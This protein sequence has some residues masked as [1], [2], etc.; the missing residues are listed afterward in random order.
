MIFCKSSTF[1]SIQFQYPTINSATFTRGQ[2]HIFKFLN[3][4]SKPQMA[5][6]I[7]NDRPAKVIGC[8]FEW[9]V[10]RKN[11]NRHR[12]APKTESFILPLLPAPILNDVHE[13]TS[14]I[15]LLYLRLYPKL[16][17]TAR[18]IVLFF[19]SSSQLQS[20]SENWKA[21]TSSASSSSSSSITAQC[22]GLTVYT[23][24]TWH[25]V[26]TVSGWVGGSVHI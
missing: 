22:C 4:Q 14:A 21:F 8:C 18:C 13:H 7:D 1:H 17:A 19:L 2:L 25:S 26:W 11:R 23:V 9:N 5:L 10:Y 3:P 20:E 15:L 6:K 24:S 16:S 12:A